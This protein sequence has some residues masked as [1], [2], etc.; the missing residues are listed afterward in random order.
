MFKRKIRFLTGTQT[1]IEFKEKKKQTN[2][3]LMRELVEFVLVKN[4]N[5]S[6]F[7]IIIC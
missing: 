3:V 2:Y 5:A 6:V 4:L 7:S 1:Q